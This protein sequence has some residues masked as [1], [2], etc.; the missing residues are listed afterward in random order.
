MLSFSDAIATPYKNLILYI[1][2]NLLI[3]FIL[4]FLK[5]PILLLHGL[6]TYIHPDHV[7]TPQN[8]TRAAIRR[9][10]DSPNLDLRKRG[11]KD[12]VDFDE[13][14]AQIFRLKLDEAHLS[15]R[16]HFTRYRNLFNYFV[17]AGSSFVLSRFVDGS[18]KD[19]F[20][21]NGD[22]VP[23]VLG[24]LGV[25]E[26]FGSLVRV[27]FEKSASR[28]SEKQLSVIV[29]VLGF[30]LGIVICFEI[31]PNLFGFRFGGADGVGRF[32]V[33]V[34]M[35]CFAAILFMPAV[36]SSRS[37]WI[38]TDQLRWN[39]SI[40]SCGFVSRVLL[41]ANYLMIVFA[42]LLW[43]NPF[44][45]LLVNNHIDKSKGSRS[46]ESVGEASELVGSLG[47]S[48]SDFA[49]FRIWCLLVSGVMQLI[50][51]RPNLQMFLNEAVLCWYQRLHA[52]KVPDLEF[53]RAKVFLHNHYLC[54]VV[55]QY[56]APPA[57]V[58]LFLGLSAIDG[59]PFRKFDFICSLF[60]C[61]VFVSEVALCL[62]W[63]IVFLS[64]VFTSVNLVLYRRGILYVS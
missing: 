34:L 15:T 31:L 63:W 47:I 54:V 51:I 11:K 22:L 17:L 36:K 4:T 41:Y 45:N 62:A 53:S 24:I 12:K 13:N 6:F 2:L 64:A 30:V 1:L 59:N 60:P 27:S 52:S 42:S 21:L 14:N 61:S 5:L 57:L 9:P 49:K 20:L 7:N 39:L 10:S 38:G 50:V 40:I 28:R 29:G 55:L 3:S 43:I 58:L 18:G 48:P 19:G 8:A 25:L 32:C 23:V 37:F 26:G 35:G 56:F 33:A 46:G 16:I 44:A